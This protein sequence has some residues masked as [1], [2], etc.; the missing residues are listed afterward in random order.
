MELMIELKAGQGKI[1]ELYQTLQALLPTL[2]KAVLENKEPQHLLW[3]FERPDGGRGFGFTGGHAHK[4]WGGPDYRKVV[5]NSLLW[6]AKVEVPPDGVNC[7]AS[8]DEFSQ[9][10]DRKGR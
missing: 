6:I 1:Q 5:L 3:V 7:T 9:Y 10:L 4:L 2:R 8:P